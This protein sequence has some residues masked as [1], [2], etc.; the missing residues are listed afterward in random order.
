MKL[1]YIKIIYRFVNAFSET[2]PFFGNVNA[3][4]ARVDVF[5]VDYYYFISW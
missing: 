1:Y 3:E 4:L 2:E 5:L